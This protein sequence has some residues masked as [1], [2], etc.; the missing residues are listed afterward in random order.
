M[1]L[2]SIAA[3]PAFKTT[4]GCRENYRDSRNQRRI[5][6]GS[7]RH[8]GSE[9]LRI[10][11]SP[12]RRPPNITTSLSLNPHGKQMAPAVFLPTF[13]SQLAQI[14]DAERDGG[15][16]ETCVDSG[17]YLLLNSQFIEALAE[18][19]GALPGT[20]PIFRAPCLEDRQKGDRPLPR[21][22]CCSPSVSLIEVCAGRGELAEALKER[23]VCLAATD[24][25]PPPGSPVL[26]A[27]AQE[28][29]V[30]YR[31]SVVLGCFVPIDA[32]VDEAVLACRSV[33]HYLV[34]GAR[35]GGEFGSAPLWRTPGWRPRSLPQ[36]SRWM[37]TRH[38][39]WTGQPHQ[40]IL[41]HGEAWC[42]SRSSDT[43]SAI[44][45]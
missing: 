43:D 14:I 27:S 37:F 16:L 2:P 17:S 26:P 4:R 1:P 15:W 34:L 12:C 7:R 23:G 8:G 32:G 19:I 29:L 13:E 45:L 25:D 18:F 44:Q 22:G 42:F 39:V 36:V 30:E 11:G 35:V 20:V 40:P 9:G 31:P 28:A 21:S 38:D 5:S 24:A 33:R 10:Q 6:F 41:R 3:V